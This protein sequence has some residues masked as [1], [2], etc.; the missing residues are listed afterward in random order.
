MSGRPAERPRIVVLQ[1]H[2]RVPLGA[3]AEPL[4]RGADV[5][6]IR[7]YEEAAAAQTAVDQWV[8]CGGYDGIVALGG[9]MGVY[10]RDTE[11]HLDDSLR[12][13]RDA[14]RR[15]LPILGLCLGS[16]LLSEALGAPVFNGAERG[17]AAEVGFKTMRLTDAGRDD[18]VMRIFAGPEPVLFWHRDTHDLPPGAAHLA[19]TD[20][21]PVA[22]YRWGARAYGLQFHLEATP[23]IL[24]VWVAVSP[25]A[26]L[27]QADRSLILEQV[28]DLEP[29]IRAR[30]ARLVELF[31]G[32]ADEGARGG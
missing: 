18:P 6:T 29:V 26:A 24:D 15:G 17:L 12:L 5:V 32:W 1:H 10:D 22:A 3:L 23:E 7:G 28:Q 2:R 30:A 16:Q 25:L 11:P 27:P 14:L 31:L 9:P 13:L 4:E 19:A 8:A 20:L 21:Y